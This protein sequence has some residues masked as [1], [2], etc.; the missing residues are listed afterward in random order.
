M[1]F[2]VHSPLKRGIE[3]QFIFKMTVLGI[4]RK[5]ATWSCRPFSV[6]NGQD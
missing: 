2:I 4:L 6:E 3:L 5:W 1:K